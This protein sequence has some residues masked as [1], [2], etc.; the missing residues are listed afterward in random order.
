MEILGYTAAEVLLWDDSDS[1]EFYVLAKPPERKRN[2]LYLVT[3]MYAY[4]WFGLNGSKHLKIEYY[5]FHQIHFKNLTDPCD[6]D[7]EVIPPE[8]IEPPE[9]VLCLTTLDPATAVDAI[10]SNGNLTATADVVSQQIRGFHQQMP[11]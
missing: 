6:C 1:E 5:P 11:T 2:T 4:Q 8:P 10:L 9:V 7:P 3:H